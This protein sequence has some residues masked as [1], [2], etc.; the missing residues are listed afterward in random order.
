MCKVK[1]APMKHIEEASKRMYKESI[2]RKL[3]MQE[4]I[5]RINNNLYEEDPNKYKKI[6]KS[7]AYSFMSDNEDGGGYNINNMFN[8]NP[9]RNAKKI[10]KKKGQTETENN[11]KKNKKKKKNN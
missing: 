1:K 11:K 10:T 7:E 2:K 5:N 3:K 8:Q 9:Y 6:V 4:K